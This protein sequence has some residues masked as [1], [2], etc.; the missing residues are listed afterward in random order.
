MYT[1]Q[2]FRDPSSTYDIPQGAARECGRDNI[3][4]TLKEVTQ[5]ARP[6]KRMLR[7][8]ARIVRQRFLISAE[9]AANAARAR[10]DCRA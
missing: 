4:R 2:E 1:I 5:R 6:F 3:V 7:Q 10:R 9:S 8:V